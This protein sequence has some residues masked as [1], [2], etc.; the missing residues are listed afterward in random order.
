M[1]YDILCPGEAL[2]E[3]MRTEIG[4]PLDAPA[5]FTGPYPSGAPF[6]FAVQ[7]ARMGASV[8][9]IG[10][11]GNDAFGD[12]LLRQL[13]ADGMDDHLVTVSETQP[14]GTAFVAYNE[15]GS[16]DFVFSPGAGAALHPGLLN[17]T[18]FEGLGYLHLM[19]STLSLHEDALAMGLRALELADAAGAQVSFDPNIRP[20]LMP[21]EQAKVAFAP[22]IAAADILLPTADELT[23]LTGKATV[24][25]A[26]EHLFVQKPERLIVMTRGAAGCSVMTSES[27]T[28]VPAYHVDERDPTGAGDCFDAGFLTRL[29]AGDNPAVAAQWANACAGLA[30]TKQGPMAGAEKIDVVRQ[31]MADNPR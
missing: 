24:A 29:L 16:R 8:G 21:V 10:C 7:A 3:I 13:R 18:M 27:V 30:V 5:L 11:V 2:V 4:Q 6:I 26:C 19:G 23:A 28:D 20:E 22:F 1:T 14:T 15:D 12:C 25:A 17:A 31:F 9:V